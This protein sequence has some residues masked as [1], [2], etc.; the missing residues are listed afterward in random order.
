MATGLRHV[1]TGNISD[2][3][4]QSTYC[5]A[6]GARLI[7]RDRYDITSWSLTGGRCAACGAR[8]AG[9][10]EG[11]PGTWGRRR[12]PVPLRAAGARAGTLVSAPAARPGR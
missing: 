7:G 6:C 12:E 4:S 1:Y 5:H 9:V 3:A 11:P 2:E 8:C 10:F